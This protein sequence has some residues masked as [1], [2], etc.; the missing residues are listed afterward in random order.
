MPLE[1]FFEILIWLET[2]KID[3]SIH[4][5]GVGQG[6]DRGGTGVGVGLGRVEI[7]SALVLKSMCPFTSQKCPFIFQNCPFVFKRY[8]FNSQKC[9]IVFQN[10]PLVFQKYLLFVYCACLF[11]RMPFFQL[12]VSSF[13]PA[14]SCSDR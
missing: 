8:L 5:G 6:W 1:K 13:C 10:C 9:S 14:Q 3:H 7:V 12:I 11:A 4:G 2:S